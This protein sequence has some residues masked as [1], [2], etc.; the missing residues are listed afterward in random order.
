MELD[1]A[2]LG[3]VQIGEFGDKHSK[4]LLVAWG[5]ESNRAI[6]V[7]DPKVISSPRTTN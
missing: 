3:S 6:F 7:M 4:N 5:Y 1:L 2:A